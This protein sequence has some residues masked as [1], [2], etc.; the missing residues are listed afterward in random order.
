MHP[1]TIIARP[2]PVDVDPQKTALVVVDMQNDFGSAGGMFDRAGIPIDA[3]RAAVEPTRQTIAAAR[4]TSM[5][6][7][8][9]K[10][11]YLPDLSDLGGADAPNRLSHRR[12]SVGDV[13]PAPDGG[14]YRVLVRDTWGTNIVDE[15][16]P[17]PDD[18][19]VYKSRFSGFYKTE[20]DD[21]LRELGVTHLIVTGCTSSVCVE[22]TVRDAFFRDYHCIV[23]E[24]CTAEPIGADFPRSNHDATMLLNEALFGAVSTSAHVI[25]A[26]S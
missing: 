11:G 5:K 20:L 12:L 23:V 13:V 4:Q 24:D 14:E 9:L 19:V 22:S 18:V 2:A 8:Y 21:L 25:S 3:I 10:M 15:L 7:V 17:E 26:L 6:I 16:K 1:V